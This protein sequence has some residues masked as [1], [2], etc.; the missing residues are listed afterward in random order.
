MAIF[1]NL[2]DFFDYGLAVW[3]FLSTPFGLVLV[4]LV[5]ILGLILGLKIRKRKRVIEIMKM[6]GGTIQLS[7]EALTMLIKLLCEQE[8]VVG[9]PKIDFFIKQQQLHAVIRLVL[10]LDKPLTVKAEALQSQIV[11]L[12]RLHLGDSFVGDVNLLITGF[13]PGEMTKQSAL[14]NNGRCID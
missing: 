3:A 9:R 6:T 2:E 13:H 1:D 10:P 14:D 12:L 8:G 7:R 4:F 11:N 5:C